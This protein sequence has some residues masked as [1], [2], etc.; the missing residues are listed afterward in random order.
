MGNQRVIY[1]SEEDDN[2]L[3]PINSPARGNNDDDLLRP[4][5]NEPQRTGKPLGDSGSTDPEFFK[6]LY[7]EQQNPSTEWVLDAMRS[8][9]GQKSFHALA[10]DNSS[11]I[12]DPT[13][14]SAK[15][16]ALG[17]FKPKDLANLTQVTTPSAPVAKQRDVYDFSVSDE[18]EEGAPTA[19]PVTR[20]KK[21]RPTVKRRMGKFDPSDG[22]AAIFTPELSTNNHALD[23]EDESPRPLRKK[24]K[25]AAQEIHSRHV[26]D[27]VDLLTMPSTAE[28]S[29]PTNESNVAYDGADAVLPGTVDVQRASDQNPP[30]S[31]FID[32]PH[33][34]TSTQKQEYLRVSGCSELDREEHLAPPDA[35]TSSQNR[36]DLRAIGY[37]EPNQE[38]HSPPPNIFRFGQKEV[39]M[40][41]MDAFEHGGGEYDQQDTLPA[42]ETHAVLPTNGSLSTVAYPTPSRYKSSIPP[43]PILDGLESRSSDVASSSSRRPHSGKT[44]LVSTLCSFSTTC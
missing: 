25:S 1:D 28:M 3:S 6:K 40:Q 23:E 15:K 42:P 41:A 27:E 36:E 30:A 5:N 10:K 17:E 21:T 33:T 8:P 32:P 4:E 14:K 9:E 13:L 20:L 35:L 12:T 24:R 11:S 37:D 7:E 44:H 26:H 43:L 16:K 38:T 34:L 22:P 39:S 31:F 2:G 29:Q 18:D 19:A